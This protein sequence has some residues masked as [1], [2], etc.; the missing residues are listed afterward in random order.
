MINGYTIIDPANTTGEIREQFDQIE[1]AMGFIPNMFKTLANSPATLGA[2]REIYNKANETEFSTT[3]RHVVFQA[4]NVVNKCSYCVPAHSTNARKGDVSVEIDETIRKN[5]PLEDPKLEALRQFTIKIVER[6]AQ[7]SVEEFSTF[8]N[9][10]WT[11]QS[12]LEVLLLVALKTLTNYTNH[13]ADIDLD[14]A[15]KPLEWS[16]ETPAAV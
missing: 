1:Q 15:F 3:E 8:I 2:V 14:D 4:V 5:S 11:R 13:L 10:G 16:P 6:R 9:A 7:V 12:A